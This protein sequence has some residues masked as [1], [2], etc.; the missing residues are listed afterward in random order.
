VLTFDDHFSCA[1]L[2]SSFQRLID[3][4]FDVIAERPRISTG[5]DRIELE[6]FLR[7]KDKHLA[8]A[9]RKVL[10]GRYTFSPFLERQ[11]P[12]DGSTELRTISIA[13]IRDSIV[14]RAL[15]DY[16]YPL[17]DGLLANGVV[18][19]Y[20]KKVSAHDAIGVIAGHFSRG[21]TYVFE[22]DLEKFFDTVDHTI[23]LAKTVQLPIDDRVQTLLRR[24]LKTGKI[25]SEQVEEHRAMT[26]KQKKFSPEPRLR[27]VPQGGVLSGLLSN[28][29]LAEF[30]RQ[31]LA[32]HCGLVRYAD[33]F[34]VCCTEEQECHDAYALARTLLEPLK[35]NLHPSPRKTKICVRADSGVEFLGFR[36][37]PSSVRVRGRNITK[38]KDRIINVIE[39]QKLRPSAEVTLRRLCW[40]LAFKIRGPNEEQLRKLAERG[41]TVAVARRS[42]IGFFRIVDDIQQVK[43]LDRWIRH[44]VKQFMWKR[45]RVRVTATQMRHLGLPSLVNSLWKAR[46]AKPIELND[47]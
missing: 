32:K 34:L 19:G 17:V 15:Y 1:A 10:S 47:E 11:I 23:L 24:F 5:A 4:H 14:Q 8:A 9:A 30:D 45:Y 26:G 28:L 43:S 22:A 44:Q 20:R 12:K 21:R 38:F 6:L 2:E 25:P 40:R 16:L 3:G 41:R 31:M 18:F 39:T 37:S 42:W 36:I 7:D 46:K 13:S 29:Y 27:G 33:D 35:V